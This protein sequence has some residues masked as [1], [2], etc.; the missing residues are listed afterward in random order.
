MFENM[1]KNYIFNLAYART[2]DIF[3]IQPLKWIMILGLG[4]FFGREGYLL[5]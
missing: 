5:A 2:Y 3:P 4:L 1:I